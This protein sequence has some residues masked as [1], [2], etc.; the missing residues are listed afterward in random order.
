M[1]YYRVSLGI[2]VKLRTSVGTIGQ[3]WCIIIDRF[4]PVF[5]ASTASHR[6]C[7]SQMYLFQLLEIAILA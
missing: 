5:C 3:Y 2:G 6:R 1:Y 4:S 7:K